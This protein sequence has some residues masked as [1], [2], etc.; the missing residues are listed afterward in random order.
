[1]TSITVTQAR[2]NLYKLIDEANETH[3]PIQITGKRGNAILLSEDDW[4]SISETLHLSG[5]PGMAESIKQGMQES[6]EDCSEELG[7]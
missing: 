1:M 6:V 7:W 5:I 2:A 3:H 4:R